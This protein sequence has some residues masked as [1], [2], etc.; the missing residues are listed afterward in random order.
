[1]S[2]LRSALPD[3]IQKL[4]DVAAQRIL[5]EIRR[6]EGVKISNFSFLQVIEN[7]SPSAKDR[8]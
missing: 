6:Q 4:D 1:V 8:L 5:D 7:V 3:I 2:S